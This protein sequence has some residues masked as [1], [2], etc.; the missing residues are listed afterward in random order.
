M[1]LTEIE[2]RALNDYRHHHKIGTLSEAARQLIA[3]A[4]M[5][6]AQAENEKGPAEA[7]TSP[8]HGSNDP[9]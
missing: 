3:G 2:G 9:R 5:T 6:A 8:S 7:A 1:M 4:L